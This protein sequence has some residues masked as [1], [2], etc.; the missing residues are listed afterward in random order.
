MR[1]K[2]GCIIGCGAA[3]LALSCGEG[4]SFGDAVAESLTILHT[5]DLHSQVWPFRSRISAAEA[6]LD[7]GEEDQLSEVGGSARLATLLRKERTRGAELWLDSGDALE[8][9]PVFQRFGGRVEVEVLGALGLSAMALG[10]HE[11]SLPSEELAALLRTAPF[12]VLAAN[13]TPSPGSP[14]SPWLASSVA[15]RSGSLRVGVVGVANPDSPPDLQGAGNRWG[16]RVEELAASVQIAVDDVAP[17]AALVIA[18]SHLGLDADR[19][20]VRST[21]G[22]DLV[23]GGHQHVLTADPQ[24]VEDCATRELQRARGCSPR[25]VPIV[26]SGAYGQFLSRV[27]VSLRPAPGR[28]GGAEVSRIGLT[29]VPVSERVE[30][31]GDV[32]EYLERYR[33]PPEPPLGF[34]AAPVTRAAPLGGDSQLGNLSADAM[35][36]ATGAD[37]VLLN[38]SGL[39]AELEPGLLLASDLGLAFPFEEPWRLVWLRGAEL[40]RGLLRSARQSAA[41]DCTSSLQIAGV[42]L[43]LRCTACQQELS[44]CLRVTRQGRPV[45]DDEHLLVA[46]PAYLTRAGADFDLLAA[47][48]AELDVSPSEALRRAIRALPRRAEPAPCRHAVSGSSAQR[49]AESFGASCPVPEARAAAI[50]RELPL[51]EGRRDGR[52]RMLP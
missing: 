46:L 10:N 32:A 21:S 16:L 9:S 37:V 43:S 18:L 4:A 14:L 39:R 52:I 33:P 17:R 45:A 31:D 38:T 30:A 48:G 8:G 49:C 28:P 40:K 5:S 19:D 50:C 24:W 22:I 47:R 51:V 26:H 12:P 23:L 35:L 36:T 1:G 44:A 41:R 27:K 15:L 11:L 7:L 25:L 20:L 34:V 3:V 13:V 42:S 6:A 2:L 29:H